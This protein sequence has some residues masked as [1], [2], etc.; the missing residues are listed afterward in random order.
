VFWNNAVGWPPSRKNWAP[1]CSAEMPSPIVSAWMPIGERPQ[2]QPG[3]GNERRC[4]TF[5]VSTEVP[6][7]FHS[8]AVAVAVDRHL[9]RVLEDQLVRAE[10]VVP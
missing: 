3:I 5:S 10:V 4:Q 2:M 9:V 1:N 6:E 7:K 8:A